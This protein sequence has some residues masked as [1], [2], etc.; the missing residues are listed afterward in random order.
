[1]YCYL[2]TIVKG[3]AARQIKKLGVRKM[4]GMRDYLF[5]RFGAGQPEIL[6]ERVRKYHLGMPDAKSGEPF[7]PRCDMEAKLDALE[8]EREYLV[9]MC[10]REQRETYEDGKEST[11]V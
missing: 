10:P 3:E 11:L 4:A 9:E 2:E 8:A 5:R 7:P 6:E 1:M